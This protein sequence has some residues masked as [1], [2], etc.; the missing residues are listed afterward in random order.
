[1][2]WKE[3]QAGAVFGDWQRSRSSLLMDTSVDTSAPSSPVLLC[4]VDTRMPRPL[5]E[6]VVCELSLLRW[7]TELEHSEEASPDP[8]DA[9]HR[10]LQTQNRVSNLLDVQP[11][12][13]VTEK[14]PQPQV[15]RADVGLVG[16]E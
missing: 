13:G 9:P 2:C 6:I 3:R 12:V 10:I 11:V 7:T 15:A 16:S 1:M 8:A 5:R 14:E 4:C